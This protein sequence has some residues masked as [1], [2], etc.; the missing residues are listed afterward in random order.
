[1]SKLSKNNICVSHTTETNLKKIGVKNTTIIENWIDIDE[2]AN[3]TAKK[4]KYDIISIGRHM[5]HKNFD[6][7]LKIISLLKTNHPKIK[8]LII[9][10]GPETLKLLKMKQALKLEKNVEILSFSR[11]HKDIYEY[12]KSSKIFVLLSELEGFSIIAFE[13]MRCGLAVITLNH[14]RNALSSFIDGKNGFALDRNE[15]E[16]AHKIDELLNN[17]K[18]L[19]KISEYSK[20]FAGKYDIKKQV[21]QIEAYYKKLR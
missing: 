16:I 1:M 2:I 12:M 18:Q 14:P 4:E 10:K 11:N 15:I 9:G 20:N 6:L 5:K 13:A 3:S 8:V 21:K 17:R 19:Q 7:L